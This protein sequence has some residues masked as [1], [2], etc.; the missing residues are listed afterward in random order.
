MLFGHSKQQYFWRRESEAFKANNT[1]PTVKL[2]ASSI[3]LLGGLSPDCTKKPKTSA[4][5]LVLGIVG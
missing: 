5:V 2:G 4:E 1:I 3:M